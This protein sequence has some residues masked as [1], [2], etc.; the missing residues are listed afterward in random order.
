MPFHVSQDLVEMLS[1]PGIW[2]TARKSSQQAYEVDPDTG[3][4]G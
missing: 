4:L 3:E 2:L 1:M